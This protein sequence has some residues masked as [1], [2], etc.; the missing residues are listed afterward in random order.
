M[1]RAIHPD[2]EAVNADSFLDIVASVVSIMIIMVLMTGLKI[3]HSPVS[4]TV[5][6][7]ASPVYRELAN[8]LAAEQSIHGDVLKAANELKR[9]QREIALRKQ[10]RDALDYALTAIRQQYEGATARATSLAQEDAGLGLQLT[11]SRAKLAELESARVALANAPVPPV[12]VESYP[13]PIGKVVD[14]RELH[15]QLRAGRI[16]FVPLETLLLKFRTDAEQK[17]YR[18]RETSELTEIIGP[19]GGF[20][21]KYTLERVDAAP[22]RSAHVRL[23][24]WTL[25]PTSEELGEPIDEALGV[26]SEFRAVLSERRAAGSTITLWTYPD[27]FDVFRR[28]KAELFKAGFPV[29]ARPLPEGFPI[30]GS[31]EGSKSAAE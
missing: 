13:T 27:S 16:A 21:F 30:S 5:A 9:F 11:Q 19:E 14:G 3:K 29:A 22:G 6:Q 4:T 12:Q 7:H 18:L 20:R 15:F 10:Q 23:K 8:D 28:L 25:V 31:P 26:K 1:A 24:R 17:V 2:T